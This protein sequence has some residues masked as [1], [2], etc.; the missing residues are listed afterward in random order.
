VARGGWIKWPML[1][2]IILFFGGFAGTM[3]LLVAYLN[4]TPISEALLLFFGS[5]M[6]LPAFLRKDEKDGEK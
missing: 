2:D 4:G 6:G 5:M 1:R 3:T